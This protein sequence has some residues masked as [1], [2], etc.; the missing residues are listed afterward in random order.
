[1]KTK[2]VIF[3]FFKTGIGLETISKILGR[4]GITYGIFSGDINDN[5]RRRV[6]EVFNSV[7]NRDGK[8]MNILFITEAGAEG[9]SLLEVNNMHILE[10][11]TREHKITQAIGRVARIFSHVNMPRNRQ[12]VNI[13]RYWSTCYPLDPPGSTIRSPQMTIDEILYNKGQVVEEGKNIFLSRLI[14]NAIEIAPPN[15]ED[16]PTSINYANKLSGLSNKFYDIVDKNIT[17]ARFDKPNSYVLLPFTT[18][19]INIPQESKNFLTRFPNIE[20]KSGYYRLPYN[21]SIWATLET[22]NEPGSYIIVNNNNVNVI[23]AFI[24]QTLK[25]PKKII[26]PLHPEDRPEIYKD[27]F[28]NIDKVLTQLSNSL[29]NGSTVSIPSSIGTNGET[30]FMSIIHEI[31][32]DVGKSNTNIKFKLY[33]G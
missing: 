7:E 31:I 10:S 20:R 2:H 8:L 29:P 16:M 17:E 30:K 18:S 4:C 23:F 13:W 25:V 19:S 5:E 11:S 12:Y 27:R 21:N 32:S 24:Q 22:R 14:Q 33:I 26:D 1:L 3:S 6:L 9:I 15:P 28:N